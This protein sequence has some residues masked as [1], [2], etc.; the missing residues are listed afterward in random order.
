MNGEQVFELQ[1]AIVKLML[2]LEDSYEAICR[3]GD[4][5]RC[6]NSALIEPS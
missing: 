3:K 6:L 1:S 2:C 5:G 4:A